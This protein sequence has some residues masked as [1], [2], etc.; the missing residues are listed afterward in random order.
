MIASL[1]LQQKVPYIAA[2]SA[3]EIGSP[4]VVRRGSGIGYANERPRDR[5]AFGVLWRRV[6]NRPGR[7]R[8]EYGQVHFLRQR[9][10]MGGL[11]CQVCG[12]S[13]AREVTRDGVLF[14]LGRD[15][16]EHAPWPAPIHTTHPPLCL[17]CAGT[18]TQVCPH[19]RDHYVALRARAPRLYGVNGISYLPGRQGP[20]RFGAE[21]LSFEDPRVRWMEAAQL[22]VRLE[23]YTLV[24]LEAELARTPQSPALSA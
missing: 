9:R 11:R 22:V 5:D 10:A 18:S 1:R 16:Y 14:L 12:G 3:E 17:P 4:R 7:G 21:T 13:T 6:T 23:T 8:P 20:K 24:D 2:W 19:L 15:E